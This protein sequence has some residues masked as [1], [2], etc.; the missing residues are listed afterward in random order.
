MGSEKKYKLMANLMNDYGSDNIN[1]YEFVGGSKGS[2]LK[3]LE[4][5]CKNDKFLNDSL[6]LDFNFEGL[7]YCV[8]GHKIKELC[9]IIKKSDDLLFDNFIIIGNCCV[10]HWNG[11]KKLKKCCSICRNTHR[12]SKNNLCGSCRVVKKLK[13][14]VINNIVLKVESK[15]AIKQITMSTYKNDFYYF[16]YHCKIQFGKY[17]NCS[18]I[19]FLKDL[20]YIKYLMNVITNT[21]DNIKPIKY[22]YL[23][24]AIKTFCYIKYITKI[25]EE[26]YNYYSGEYFSN[27]LYYYI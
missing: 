2:N 21:D 17:K 19:E 8:C 6:N 14:K 5:L 22:N 12:N 16:L 23:N 15:N 27:D 26:L 3:Y 10:R 25:L 7:T 11:G 9:F 20:D 13:D 18:I 4:Q 1:D 24:N